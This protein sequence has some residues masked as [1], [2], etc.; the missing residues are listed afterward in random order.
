[1]TVVLLLSAPYFDNT[2]KKGNYSIINIIHH[3]MQHPAQ[4]TH[5]ISHNVLI[6]RYVIK[7]GVKPPR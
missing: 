3:C 7:H 1:M 6:V 2:M 5:F 4:I